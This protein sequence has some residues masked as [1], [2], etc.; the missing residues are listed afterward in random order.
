MPE[1]KDISPELGERLRNAIQDCDEV[2]QRAVTLVDVL[3]TVFDRSLDS[4]G[5]RITPVADDPLDVLIETPMG[6]GRLRLE[7]RTNADTILGR[8]LLQRRTVD[9]Y[10]VPIWES[11]W[12]ITVPPYGDITAGDRNGQVIRLNDP[13]S[14]STTKAGLAM[15]YAI[16]NGPQCEPA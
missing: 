11:V 6:N 16:A 12:A 14:L 4:I 13:K 1:F 9:Q 10:D 5:I 8:L 2:R 15:L 7:W 3:K